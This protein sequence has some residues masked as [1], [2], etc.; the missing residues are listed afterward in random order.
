M[1]HDQ[2][3]QFDFVKDKKYDENLFDIKDAKDS[4]ALEQHITTK[5]T[6][7]VKLCDGHSNIIWFKNEWMKI[8]SLID[9]H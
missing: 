1:G 2:N 6:N 7:H 8:L 3:I 9:L 4:L 5:K